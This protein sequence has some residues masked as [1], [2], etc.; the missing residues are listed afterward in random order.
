[1]I[2]ATITH[3]KIVYKI[4][5]HTSFSFAYLL[6]CRQHQGQFVKYSGLPILKICW[7]NE[8]PSVKANMLVN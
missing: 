6:H 7:L 8:H 4:H 3:S 2:H 5:I 1:M